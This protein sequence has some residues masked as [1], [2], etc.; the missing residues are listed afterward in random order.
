MI[1]LKDILNELLLNEALFVAL[2]LKRPKGGG[3]QSKLKIGIKNRPVTGGILQ[4]RA[5]MIFTSE[6]SRNVDPLAGKNLKILTQYDQTGLW[7]SKNSKGRT[8]QF[9]DA[10]S[11]EITNA[12]DKL[13][14]HIKDG[15]V[16]NATKNLDLVFSYKKSKLDKILKTKYG[17]GK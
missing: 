1:K 14:Y 15:H 2:V 3:F 4:A 5:K 11:G 12:G 16:I 10:I 17:V 9:I 7:G 6:V 8:R 13:N